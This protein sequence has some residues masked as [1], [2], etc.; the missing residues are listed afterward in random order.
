MNRLNQVT[1]GGED[2]P[3]SFFLISPSSNENYELRHIFDRSNETYGKAGL[4]NLERT[5]QKRKSP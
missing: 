1:R 2:G 4:S 3:L 5:A